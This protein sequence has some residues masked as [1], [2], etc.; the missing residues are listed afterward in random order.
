MNRKERRR[1]TAL[2]EVKDEPGLR[3]KLLK[4]RK[5]RAAGKLDVETRRLQRKALQR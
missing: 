3:R 4:Q 1:A 2:F 5:K